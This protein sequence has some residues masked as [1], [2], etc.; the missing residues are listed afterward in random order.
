MS[1]AVGVLAENWIDDK[2]PVSTLNDKSFLWLDGN[3]GFGRPFQHDIHNGHFVFM[4]QD[5]VDHQTNIWMNRFP[6]LPLAECNISH[7]NGNKPSGLEFIISIK[8]C[9]SYGNLDFRSYA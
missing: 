6:S 2:P 4:R 7:M 8:K 1:I 9:Y 3:G 5:A